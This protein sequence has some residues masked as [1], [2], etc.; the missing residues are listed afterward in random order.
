MHQEA[1]SSL[2]KSSLALFKGCESAPI[3]EGIVEL[4]TWIQADLGSAGIHLEVF[5]GCI[6]HGA[7]RAALCNW[8]KSPVF[9]SGLSSIE[10]R[11]NDANG[12]QAMALCPSSVGLPNVC[13][14]RTSVPSARLQT[15]YPPNARRPPDA[16][17]PK[18]LQSFL[19]RLSAF[20]I[21]CLYSLHDRNA[22]PPT[23]RRTK[24]DHVAGNGHHLAVQ[25][26]VV[27]VLACMNFLDA[28]EDVQAAT[29]FRVN[30]AYWTLGDAYATFETSYL[31]KM[32]KE[33]A[34]VVCSRT[35]TKQTM[36]ELYSSSDMHCYLKQQDVFASAK[37]KAL[38]Q[39]LQRGRK[40]KLLTDILGESILLALSE[41]CVTRIDKLLLSDLQHAR[42]G[43]DCA[44][45]SENSIR[46]V[47]EKFL[48]YNDQ[49]RGGLYAL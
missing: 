15:P 27:Q 28:M 9:R 3:L 42:L 22:V 10:A 44:P 18:R 41:V 8:P 23:F 38:N 14:S 35:L 25:E 2:M 6:D 7:I 30:C 21:R 47:R 11:E 1:L 39:R 16:I 48:P 17:G 46:L 12:S 19:T 43:I 26:A 49:V 20:D 33:G 5:N 37:K 34:S 36:A 40:F 45:I 24:A 29:T 13:L 32:S 4:L 31:E